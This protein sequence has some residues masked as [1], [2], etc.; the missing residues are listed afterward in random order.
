MNKKTLIPRLAILLIAAVLAVAC[1][2][3]AD[4]LFERY[5][6][7]DKQ[8][9]AVYQLFP[10][11]DTQY[12]DCMYV[13]GQLV[14]MTNDPQ[15]VWTITS[16]V[17]LGDMVI[18]FSEPLAESCEIQVYFDDDG[19]GFVGDKVMTVWAEA[20]EMEVLVPLAR[21]RYYGLRVD[22]NGRVP[23]SDIY[24]DASVILIQS[25]PGPFRV[26]RCLL[27]FLAIAAILL[28][29]YQYR[30]DDR[31]RG[32]IDAY[33][34]FMGSDLVWAFLV[35][36]TVGVFF[37]VYYHLRDIT[38]Q[39]GAFHWM[40]HPFWP[41]TV[42]VFL[43]LYGCMYVCR[44]RDIRPADWLYENRWM[45]GLCL[46]ILCVLLNL[47][48][49]SLHEW[50][51]YLGSQ[52]KNGLLI[53]VSRSIRSDEWAKQIGVLEALRYEN[54]PA[55]STL[56]RA[57]GTENVLIAGHVAWDISALFRPNT[58]G[59]LLFGSVSYGLA[60]QNASTIIAFFLLAF[61][62]FMM[63]SQNRKL[64]FAFA[65]TLLFSPFVQWWTCFDLFISSF[66][67]LLAGRKY[68][69][70]QSVRTKL[71]CAIVVV[72]FAGNFALLMYPAW[73][74]PA[75]YILLAGLIWIIIHDH[76]QIKL[77]LKVDLPI[78]GGALLFLA[79][80]GAVIYL[81]SASAIH[82]M[83][84]TV[85]PGAVRSNAPMSVAKLFTNYLNAFSPYTAAFVPGP[86]LSEAADFITFFPIGIL[87]CVFA[88]IRN[89]RAD[90]F[91]I[92]MIALSAFLA[93]FTFLDVSELLRKLTLM[94]FTMSQRVLP[95]FG[96]V[97][98]VLLFRGVS[99]LNG[100][101]RWYVAVP[102]SALFAWFVIREIAASPYNP[103]RLL[104]FAIL[105]AMIF[106]ILWAALRSGRDARAMRLFATV[107]VFFALFT[108]GMV[109]PIQAGMPEV[110][111]SAIVM[112][113]RDVV[114]ADPSGKWLVE[115]LSYPYGMVPLMGGAPTINCVNNYPNLELWY[116]LDPERDDEIAY[117]RYVSQIITT[118]VKDEDTAFSVG[119]VDD[120]MDLRLNARDLKTMDV[121]YILTN[122]SLSG[123]STDDV[124]FARVGS[125]H[126]FNIYR[127]EYGG[128]GA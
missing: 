18:R 82:D 58:W 113:I 110:E 29:I 4:H 37:C 13:G 30:R 79:A 51:G 75:A 2:L 53:G 65:C 63:I 86:N 90:S 9:D 55:F 72:I 59:Y 12:I 17:P 83:I 91:S 36:V 69:T 40:F 31:W 76:R 92:V 62:F 105:A 109:H 50:A 66:A 68:L 25:A 44:D 27:A 24:C 127:V 39:T 93:A 57:T 70:T 20:E 7:E 100:G 126:I 112:K 114:Q 3:A 122:R 49:S 108:G 107:M 88:M 14:P 95:W 48:I 38:A 43:M 60:F 80:C 124:K 89:R 71:L 111:E 8:D 6:R 128:D 32:A 26:N 84:N 115:N 123:L 54:Y 96:F 10:G 22:I 33:G 116:K 98:I 41:V 61:D 117:N 35:S 119:W 19:A 97:Q 15:M 46:L 120:I 77:R 73:Q 45:I 103:G 102:V 125:A 78:I 94:S 23:L 74:V 11:G 99:L 106:V 28:L 85:Y 1:E 104:V 16:D 56:I 34:G 5:T 81:R 67:L 42:A 87:L 52:D 21:G 121:S 101:V 64:S 118:L 47:N